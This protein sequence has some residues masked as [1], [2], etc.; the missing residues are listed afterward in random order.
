MS[1]ADNKAVLRR[2]AEEFNKRNF[3][4]IE[5]VF[6]PHF[7]LHDATHPHWPRGLEGARK[8][9]TVMLAAAPNLQVTVEDAVAEGDKVVV[10]WTFRGTRAGASGSDA[11]PPEEPTTA[12]GIGIYRLVEGRIE[13]DWGI[14]AR[15]LTQIP[16][17]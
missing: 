9:F 8:M 11:A 16:W 10:R 4:V 5:E 6:S 15:C 14:A 1:P 3:A 2:L 13:E 7:V 12:L 17:E